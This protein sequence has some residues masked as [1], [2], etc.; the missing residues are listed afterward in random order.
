[1]YDIKRHTD[2]KRRIKIDSVKDDERERERESLER[3]K[4]NKDKLTMKK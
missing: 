4:D 2:R 3:K 1:M